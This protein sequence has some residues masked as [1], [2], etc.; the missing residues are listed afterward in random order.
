[1]IIVELEGKH[2]N[3][4][5]DWSE[6]S[7]EVFEKVMKQSSL[8]SEYKSQILYGIELFSILTGATIENLK[9]MTRNS[10]EELSKYIKWVNEDI[11]STKRKS[12]VIDKIEYMSI[13]NLNALSMGDSVS[14]EIMINESDQSTLLGNIL[15]ILVRR[16]NEVSKDGKVVKVPAPFDAEN[17]NEIKELFKKN[18]MVA[19]V[20]D[21][22]DFF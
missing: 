19:D 20:I 4:P 8:L 22:K 16:V 15:P 17:Y 7:L 12:W 6:V 3:M 2:Y 14:L 21:L 13:E 5:S 9:E 10:F 1:M 11:K 18:L